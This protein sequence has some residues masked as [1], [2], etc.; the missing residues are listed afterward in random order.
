MNGKSSKNKY[1]LFSLLWPPVVAALGAA[2]FYYWL[3]RRRE[4]EGF[5]EDLHFLSPTE[6]L[7]VLHSKDFAY[8]HAYRYRESIARTGKPPHRALQAYE[9]GLLTFTEAEISQIRDFIR[10]VPALSG[11]SWSFIKMAD[12]LDWSFPYTV[13]KHVI[14]PESLVLSIATQQR[15]KADAVTLLHEHLHILQRAEP[16]KYNTF[17]AKVYNMTIQDKLVL[18]Q[19]LDDT[20]VTNPDGL[21]IR[22][23]FTSPVADN[24]PLSGDWWFCMQLDKNYNILKTAY[25]VHDGRVDD[26]GGIPL[27]GFARF[28]DG[29]TNCYH[30]NEIFSYMH[31]QNIIDR[32]WSASSFKPVKRI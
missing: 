2:G 8:V 29:L 22:W 30:P 7:R 6:A 15:P 5:V 18:S 10:L 31:S 9:Q 11:I 19:S 25:P 12:N 16:Q 28:F 23:V 14:L 4:A 17:Y 1:R 26:S 21:D 20:L 24:D 3:Q 27:A 13:G 32:T